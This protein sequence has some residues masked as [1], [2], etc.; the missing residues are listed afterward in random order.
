M[1]ACASRM[2]CSSTPVQ[3][4][5]STSLRS[6]C[7]S[8]SY[9]AH[10]RSY[11]SALTV[12]N[13]KSIFTL[14]VDPSQSRFKDLTYHGLCSARHPQIVVQ[15]LAEQRPWYVRSLKRDWEGSTSS[16]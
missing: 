10:S 7:V 15:E 9:S 1:V 14:L 5:A 6:D 3:M 2:V 11:S 8:G 4:P 16:V 12:V 13:A